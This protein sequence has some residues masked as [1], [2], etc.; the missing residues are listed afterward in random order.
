[1]RASGVHVPGHLEDLEIGVRGGEI[2]GIAGL[3]GSGRSEL[4]RALAGMDP[5]S[6]GTLAVGGRPVRWPRDP[7]QAL[8][9]GIALVPEDRKAQGLVLG[10]PVFDNINIP[11]FASVSSHGVLRRGTELREA[12]ERASRVALK[13]NVL[14]RPVRTLSGGNQQKALIARWI[15]RR[16]RV[17]LVDEPTRGID[18]GAKVDVFTLLDQIAAEGLG[19]IMVS[20]ELEEVVAH[21][22]RVVAIA[23]GRAIAEFAAEGLDVSDVLRAI[24]RVEET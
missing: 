14:G 4:L 10:M 12:E 9:A 17:L 23:G 20:S 15:G 19:V 7:R 2:L 13:R 18:V 1:M 22:D 3:V 5:A 11:A 24:F 6:S 21:S 8:R 16:L